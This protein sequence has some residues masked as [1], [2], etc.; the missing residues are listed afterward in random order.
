[1]KTIYY[2][3]LPTMDQYFKPKKVEEA[4]SL[5]TNYGDQAK[6]LAGGT[7]LLVQMR[8]RSLTPKCIVDITNIPELNYVKQDRDIL[9]IGALATIRAVELSPIVKDKYVNLYEATHQMATTQI[10]NMGTVVGNIC[11]ASP[12]ADTAPPL[13]ALKSSVEIIGSSGTRIIPLEEFFLGPGQTALEPHEMVLAIHVPE[14]PTGNGTA[15]LRVTRVAADL[16]KINVSSVVIIKNGI[17]QDARI[18]LGGIAPTPIRARKAEALL[19]DSR[20]NE[21]L[22]KKAAG[23]AAN[24]TKPITDIRSTKEYRKELSEV[25]VR[26]TINISRQRAE[27]CLEG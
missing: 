11:R 27:I 10:R 26:R 9:K 16:A 21:E 17:C 6:I 14:L 22:I 4:V 1:L 18:A 24:E 23:I 25:L 3:Y 5:I 8:D 15:F 12:A 7:D 13:L 2:N 20:L 19:R